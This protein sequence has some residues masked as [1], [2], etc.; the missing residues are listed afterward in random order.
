MSI[1]ASYLDTIYKLD[2]HLPNPIFLYPTPVYF[3]PH[4]VVLHLFY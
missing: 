2:G 1:N 4:S 3:L